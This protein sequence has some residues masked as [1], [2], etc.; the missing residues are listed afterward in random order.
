MVV[1]KAS[2]F[3][4]NAL[5]VVIIV[6]GSV[7]GKLPVEQQGNAP[8]KGAAALPAPVGGDK[9]ALPVGRQG[10]GSLVIINYSSF[11]FE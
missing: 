7:Q 5:L 11:K 1:I 6:V 9:A 8:A 3:W 2:I 4:R 10:Q